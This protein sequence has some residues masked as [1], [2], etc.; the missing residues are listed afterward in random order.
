MA[1]DAAR[2]EEEGRPQGV[3]SWLRKC[4]A[5]LAA[6][7]S[8]L[9]GDDEDNEPWTV[10]HHAQQAVEKAIKALLVR[11]GLPVPRRHDIGQLMQSLPDPARSI[12]DTRAVRLSEYATGV[13]YPD[14]IDDLWV[15]ADEVDWDAAREALHLAESVVATVTAAVRARPTADDEVG[16]D[17]PALDE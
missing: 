4:R 5:D 7:R 10:A 2:S 1:E 11:D 3:E 16:P 12:M 9:K 6:A 15:I 17:D 13:R 8:I 14:T